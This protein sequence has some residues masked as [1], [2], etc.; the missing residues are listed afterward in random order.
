MYSDNRPF[1]PTPMSFSHLPTSSHAHR[2]RQHPIIQSFPHPLSRSSIIVA[3]ATT[4]PTAHPPPAR[5][6]R[7]TAGSSRVDF[8]AA[9][10]HAPRSSVT[11]PA[12]LL[13]LRYST[14]Q[15]PVPEPLLLLHS[16][17]PVQD[18]IHS[19]P[20]PSPT[21]TDS[22]PY[23][24]SHLPFHT[25]R[26][27]PT[28]QGTHDPCGDRIAVHPTAASQAVANGSIALGTP[29][30]TAMSLCVLALVP[31]LLVPHNHGF[32]F[33]CPTPHHP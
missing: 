20:P 22:G 19:A 3:S 18:D 9:S 23:H 31:V 5:L 28:G 32:R 15:A 10:P 21:A 26:P 33:R 11:C 16:R 1:C 17:G 7:P 29:G 8:L 13:L 25:T 24:P 27:G 2:T 12:S 14:E 30:M 4:S 6:S